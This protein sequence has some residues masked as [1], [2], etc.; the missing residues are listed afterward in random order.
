ML[1][2]VQSSNQD[3]KENIYDPVSTYSSAG[4]L[5]SVS[6]VDRVFNTDSVA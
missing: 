4:S 6:Q 3:W 1:D 2:L 5:R